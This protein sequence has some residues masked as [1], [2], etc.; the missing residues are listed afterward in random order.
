MVLNTVKR[1]TSCWK[2]PFHPP[3]SSLPN[4]HLIDI[5]MIVV[6]SVVLCFNV[7]VKFACHH[8]VLWLEF[9]MKIYYR[10][11]RFTKPLPLFPFNTFYTIHKTY[12]FDSIEWKIWDCFFLS[13]CVCV[14]YL[15]LFELSY[16]LELCVKSLRKILCW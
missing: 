1:K 13:L 14:C 4:N 16:A 7:F 10:H 11:K 12:M 9:A 2:T 3:S 5:F 8:L 15:N 6:F